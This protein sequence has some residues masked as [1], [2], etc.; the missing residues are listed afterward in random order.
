MQQPVSDGPPAE[1]RVA[2]RRRPPRQR[3]AAPIPIPEAPGR[4]ARAIG[5]QD[6]LE[7]HLSAVDERIEQGIRAVRSAAAEAVRQAAAELRT[8]ARN[9]VIAQTDALRGVLSHAEERFRAITLRLQRMEG[10]IRQLARAQREAST[11]SHPPS[12]QGLE[13]RLND[14][15]RS[16]TQLGEA[17]RQAM[18]ELAESHRHTVKRLGVEQRLVASWLMERQRDA[19]V[20]MGRRTGKGIVAVARRLQQDLARRIDRIEAAE[21]GS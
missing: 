18:K 21:R 14:L 16:V 13:D 11:S 7:A 10:S 17:Q 2:S 5:L 4:P 9:G 12:V 8:P 19:V 6:L 20:D 1:I 15:A 3:K